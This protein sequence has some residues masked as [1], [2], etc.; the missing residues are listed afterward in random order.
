MH[1]DTKEGTISPAPTAN[2]HLG[3]WLGS[4]AI[5]SPLPPG[6]T[7]GSCFTSPRAGSPHFCL[8]LT[9]LIHL[10]CKHFMG[11]LLS[12]ASQ[13][14]SALLV[15]RLVSGFQ[16]APGGKVSAPRKMLQKAR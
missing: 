4:R 11:R 13:F 16:T 1:Q 14:D 7:N 2:K 5:N 3:R 6:C 8:Q 10:M 9:P 12:S 15:L